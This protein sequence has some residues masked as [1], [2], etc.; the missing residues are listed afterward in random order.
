MKTLIISLSLLLTFYGCNLHDD[1]SNNSTPTHKTV[2]SDEV[3]FTLDIPKN[4]FLLDDTLSIIFKFRNR[5]TSK[6]E[7]YISDISEVA[8]QLID[9]NGYIATYYPNIGEPHRNNL[10]LEPDQLWQFPLI[11]FFKDVHG[12]YIDRGK[13]SLF[14]FLA[15]NNSPKL[16]LE[17]TVN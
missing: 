17:I 3:E 10:T 14:V 11:G 7:F 8:Y 15:S 5:S 12:N 2:I 4:S 9:P 6:K 16:K 13:Y 1:S